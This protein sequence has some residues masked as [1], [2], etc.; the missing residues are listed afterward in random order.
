MK[1]NY[2]INKEQL[3]LLYESLIHEA[4]VHAHA[5]DRFKDRIVGAKGVNRNDVFDVFSAIDD[6]KEFHFRKNTSY[7]IRLKRLNVFLRIPNPDDSNKVSVGD[8]VWC[9]IRRNEIRTIFLRSSSQTKDREKNAMSMNV[10]VVIPSINALI[11]GD[12]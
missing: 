7:A 11:K 10:D 5:T 1:I 12:Y 8:E 9:I 4:T 2:K 6:L 3:K